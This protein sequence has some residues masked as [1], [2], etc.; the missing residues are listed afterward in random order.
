MTQ[1]GLHLHRPA[2]GQSLIGQA[3]GEAPFFLSGQAPCSPP[4]EQ[5][6]EPCPAPPPATKRRHAQSMRS[7]DA[8]IWL[9]ESG[10]AAILP[11]GRHLLPASGEHLVQIALV[12]HVK[13]QSVPVDL[14]TRW[15]ATASSTA[16]RLDATRLRWT[17]S[18]AR[19]KGPWPL[20]GQI[21]Q[22]RSVFSCLIFFW[23]RPTSMSPVRSLA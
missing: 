1:S 12:P 7:R 3:A 20:I 2:F 13:D 16:P 10:N 8:L 15:M 19:H 11:Q 22:N 17:S 18:E 23:L 9:R 6:P 5:R 21:L 14:N 4:P